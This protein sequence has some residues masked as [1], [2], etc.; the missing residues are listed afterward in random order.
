MAVSSFGVFTP[1][2]RGSLPLS[3]S[4]LNTTLSLD[5]PTRACNCLQHNTSSLD[6]Y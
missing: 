4:L 1:A 6:F 2:V 5:S 3:F